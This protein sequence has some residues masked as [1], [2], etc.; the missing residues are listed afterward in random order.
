MAAQGSGRG[1]LH[2]RVTHQEA[3]QV[4]RPSWLG[5][6]RR[7]LLLLIQSLAMLLMVA[8]ILLLLVSGRGD[9]E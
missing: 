4:T 2:H 1:L 9:G 7:L 6:R 8:R 5:M 3:G